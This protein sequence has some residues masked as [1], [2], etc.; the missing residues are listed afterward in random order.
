MTLVQ[1]LG[2]SRAPIL[3]LEDDLEAECRLDLRNGRQNPAA[4]RQ[5][6]PQRAMA[7]VTKWIYASEGLGDPRTSSHFAGWRSPFLLTVL[8]SKSR[9]P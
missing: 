6:V 1:L 2:Y 3:P 4:Q 7:R 5:I 9:T 8:F